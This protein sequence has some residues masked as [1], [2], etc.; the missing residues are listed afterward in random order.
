MDDDDGN[1]GFVDCRIDDYSTSL[2]ENEHFVHSQVIFTGTQSPFNYGKDGRRINS[3][4]ENLQYGNG[5]NGVGKM[6][7]R[8]DV[9]T[10]FYKISDFRHSLDDDGNQLMD[11]DFHVIETPDG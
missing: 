2:I 5:I 1:D 7:V 3:K 11:G 10:E 9:G 8:I 6:E 4:P